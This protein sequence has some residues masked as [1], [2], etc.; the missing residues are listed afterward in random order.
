[1]VEYKFIKLV[2]LPNTD[3]KKFEAVFKNIKTNREKKIKFGAQG[4]MDF[5]LWNAKLKN[6][7]EADKKRAAYIKRHSGMNEKWGDSGV[8]SAGWFS[9]WFLWEKRTLA[10]SKKFII[11]K[12]AKAG[13]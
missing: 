12:L 3:K 8:M 2:K 4:M 6:D 13:Y 1:M 5:I 7:L 10:E 9:R 11:N